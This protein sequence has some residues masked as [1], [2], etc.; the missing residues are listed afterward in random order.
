VFSVEH[1]VEQHDLP[2][3]DLKI[4]MGDFNAQIGSNTEGWEEV[5]G[6]QAL[7]ERTDN[8]DRLLSY[9]SIN[10]L[11]IGGSMFFHKNIYKGTWRSPDGTTVNQ[12]DHFCISKRWRHH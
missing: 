6:A 7:R 4:V 5:I 10:R 1:R 11:K 8:G 9:C 3:Y 12:V 2:S